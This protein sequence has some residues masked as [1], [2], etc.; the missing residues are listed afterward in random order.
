MANY[1]TLVAQAGYLSNV[2]LKSSPENGITQADLSA[3]EAHARAEIDAA[4]APFYDTSAWEDETPGIIERIADMLSSAE[5]LNY[6][7]QRGDTAQGDDTHLPVVIERDARALLAMSAKGTISVVR[8]DGVIQAR[9]DA[10]RLPST[11]TSEVEFFPSEAP[12]AGPRNSQSLEE[13]Y[14]TRGA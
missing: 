11:R 1:N 2:R 5:V 3:A 13:L 12:V 14:R 4:L 10:P 8:T 9:L 7:Y 6:K